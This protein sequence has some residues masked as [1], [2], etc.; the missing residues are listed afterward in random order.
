MRK[1][2][3]GMLQLKPLSRLAGVATL[4]SFAGFALA[5]QG[6]AKTLVMAMQGTP[7]SIDGEQALTSEGE[8]MMAN[9]HGGDLFGYK[10]LPG[11]GTA[12]SVDLRSTG[13][14][15]VYGLTAESWTMSPD[16]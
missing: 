3:A 1:G 9:V 4:A 12:L 10:I 8:M 2:D 16:G 13:D 5:G 14:Q 7:A 15:G 11:S 6:E